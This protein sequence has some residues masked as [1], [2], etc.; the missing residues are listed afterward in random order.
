MLKT[1]KKQL[2][3]LRLQQDLIEKNFDQTQTDR[4]F[5]F[6]VKVMTQMVDVE[7][8]S[9]FVYDPEKKQAW[10]KAALDLEEKAIVVP[11]DETVVGRVI[12]SGEAVIESGLE[13]REGV[14]KEIAE[15]T[16]F[17]SRD[18]LCI[19][20]KS[21]D[22]KEVTGAIQLINKKD[23][24]FTEE[25]KKLAEDVAYFLQLNVESIFLN[26]SALSLSERVLN[27]AGK[28]LMFGVGIA[29]ALLILLVLYLVVL[30][31]AP[32]LLS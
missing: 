22:D 15:R 4:L 3:V 32:H 19:P 2:E 30:T 1:I 18:V 31:A 26:Q 27:F 6:Y 17:V 5:G 29:G 24:A 9:I 14:H 8:C 16:G 10:L 28:V 11:T 23:G 13:H 25:D 20:I 12:R 21:L 7:R